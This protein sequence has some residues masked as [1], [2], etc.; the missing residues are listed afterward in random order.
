MRTAVAVLLLLGAGV[1][2]AQSPVAQARAYTKAL[3]LDRA[4]AALKQCEAT[5]G[6]SY[7]EGLEFYELSGVVAALRGDPAGARRAFTELLVLAPSFKLQGRRPPKVT[8][9]FAEA[10]AS[11]RERGPV[12]VTVELD[13][14]EGAFVTSLRLSA[15][16]AALGGQHAAQGRVARRWGWPHGVRRAQRPASGHARQERLGA[17]SCAWGA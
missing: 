7:A 15:S 4:A 16:P 14:T 5:S 9:P 8:T 17:R 2:A 11:A 1:A 3:E 10:K 13:A 12:N 6:L